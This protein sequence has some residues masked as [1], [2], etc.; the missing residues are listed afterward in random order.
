MTQTPGTI[1]RSTKTARGRLVVRAISGLRIALCADCQ[2]ADA[3]QVV[4]NEPILKAASLFHFG[5]KYVTWPN[6]VA[7]RPNAPFVIGTVG[8]SPVISVLQTIAKRRT[9]QDRKMI[10]R[11]IVNPKQAGSCDMVFVTKLAPAKTTAAVIAAIGNA[12][13]LLVGE[14]KGFFLAGGTIGFVIKNNFLKNQISLKNALRQNLKI[15]SQ[16]LKL[17]DRVERPKKAR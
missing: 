5:N 10:V 16:L 3:Q 17:A 9:I 4:N 15:S 12:P 13:V 2:S 11:R 14:S 7:K 6:L 1:Q 8:N